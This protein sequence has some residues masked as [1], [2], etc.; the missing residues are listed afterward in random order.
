MGRSCGAAFFCG[1]CTG[2]LRVRMR[3]ASELLL[4]FRR[5]R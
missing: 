5:N 4:I 1:I 3:V 2:E